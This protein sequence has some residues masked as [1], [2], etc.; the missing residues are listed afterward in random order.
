MRFTPN[1][2]PGAYAT[3][4]YPASRDAGWNWSAVQRLKFWIKAQ[5]PNIPG[6]Q[7]AGPVVRLLGRNGYLELKP[8]KDANLLNDP[9]FSEA[10]WLWMQVVIPI[11][12]DT[13]WQRVSAGDFTLEHVDALSLSLDSWGGEPF[14]VWLDG[15][16]IE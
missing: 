6:W 14:T 7:N 3:V 11:A 5:N 8:A 1:P 13:R 10:R 15:L 4:I 12:G 2:Y 9:P 16:S